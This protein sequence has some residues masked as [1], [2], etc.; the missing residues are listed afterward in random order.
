MGQAMKELLIGC[1]NSRIKRLYI[2]DD[3]EW[4]DLTTLDMDASCKPDVVHDLNDLPLPFEDNTFNSISAF[5]VLEHCGSQG[6]WRFFFDQW[7]D[8]W[9]IVTPDGLF[10]GTCP[11]YLSPWAFGDPSHT[12]IIG[13]ECLTFLS[14]KSYEE[15][16][17][18]TSMTDFRHYYKADWLL[19][20]DKLQ[21]E[22][23]TQE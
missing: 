1:G 22:T 21:K 2:T 5:E 6:D 8:F 9:R 15:R 10:F 4:H 11:H 18:S 20:H 23:M 3:I 7:T 13:L 12:R 14:Q 19:V 16:V 17:G